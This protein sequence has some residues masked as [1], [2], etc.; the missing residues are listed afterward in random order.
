MLVEAVA[1]VILLGLLAYALLGGADF[2]GGVWDLFASGPRKEAQREAIADAMGPVW[3]ANHVWLIFVI[4]LL[5]TCFP[6]AFAALSIAFFVPFHLV[7]LG[8]IL[9]GAAFVFRAY[10]PRMGRQPRLWGRVFG[11]A[12]LLTP[13]VLGMCLGAVA[14][15]DLRVSEDRALAGAADSWLQPEAWLVGVLAVAACAFLAAVY[16]CVETEGELQEDFRKRALVATLA[17]GALALAALP[18][19]R[20]AAPHLWPGFASPQGIALVAAATL[21]GAATLLLLLRRRFAL[22]RVAAAAQ[23][24]ALLG[25]WGALLQYP[26]LVYPDVRLADA[27]APAGVLAATLWIVGIG[28]LFLAPALAYLFRIFKGKMPGVE[29]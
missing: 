22:A 8:I 15:G 2:G 11:V 21:S 17:L 6:D 5:F 27:A 29:A 10:G 18:V 23:V 9:R 14:S 3:E 24:V 28:A 13:L 26:Y 16:L 25:G 1:G 19:L 12:S 4:T 20:M 7:L